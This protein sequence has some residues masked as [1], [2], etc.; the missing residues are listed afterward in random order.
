VY[1]AAILLQKSEAW[2]ESLCKKSLSNFIIIPNKD[3]CITNISGVVVEIVITVVLVDIDNKKGQFCNKQHFV[4]IDHLLCT[5]F[6]Y[7]PLICNKSFNP[8]FSRTGLR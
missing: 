1:L 4:F 6:Y 8:L 3:Q 2:E 5:I 7:E